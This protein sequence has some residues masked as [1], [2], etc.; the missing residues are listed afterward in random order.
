M[1]TDPDSGT[2]AGQHTVVSKASA[3]SVT[4]TVS[5][6]VALVE[7]KGMKVFAV[8]DHSGEA[9]R[10]GMTLRETKVVIF[11]APQAGTPVMHA[12]PLAALDLPLKVLIWDD[13]GQT[14]V[15]YTAPAELAGRYGI[16]AELAANLAGIDALTDALVGA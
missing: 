2:T 8:I 6:L 3:S 11:G 9:A 5:R 7:S 14:T 10:V 12:H 1:S 4:A 16:G 13:N 15:T